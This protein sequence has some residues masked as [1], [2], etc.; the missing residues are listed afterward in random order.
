VAGTERINNTSCVKLVGTQQSEDWEWDHARADQ[1]AWR[2]QDTVWVAPSLGVA[3]KVERVIERREPLRRVPT[4]ESRLTYQLQSSLVYPG[5]FF[6]ERRREIAKARAF[7]DQALPLI[8]KP[9]LYEEQLNA[10]LKR[11]DS[12]VETRPGIDPYRKVMLQVK[13]RLEAARRGEAP[14]ESVTDEAEKNPTVARLGR[15]A[16]DF[17]AADLLRPES[18]HLHRLLGRPILL[19]FFNPASPTAGD[20]LR[21]ANEKHRA[22]ATVLGMSVSDDVEAVKKQHAELQLNFPIA[23]GRGFYVSYGVDA[24]PRIVVLDAQG[25]VRGTYTGWGSE[26]AAEVNEV[27]QTLKRR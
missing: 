18:Y 27:L 26:T 25:I 2:R 15:R 11:I 21:F 23:A 6:E 13:R 24:T 12:Y 4:Q 20:V 1:T 22:G 7:A 19:V 5:Q 9:G 3:Y 10:L 8:R 14:P 17:V 16:P